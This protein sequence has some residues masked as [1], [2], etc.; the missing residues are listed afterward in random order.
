MRSRAYLNTVLT[1]IA[2]LL[3][4]HLVAGGGGNAMWFD[5]EAQARQDGPAMP[6]NAAEQRK[7]IIAQLEQMNR[8]LQAI[9]RRMERPVDV[10][11]IE[12]PAIHIEGKG[13]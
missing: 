1:V 3:A 5:S 8:R 13:D 9:E 4:L 2:A 12:M 11:V 7:L 10:K 6:F